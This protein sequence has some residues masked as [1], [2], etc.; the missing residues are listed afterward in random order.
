MAAAVPAVLGHAR[1]GR[2]QQGAQGRHRQAYIL[3]Y[4]LIHD[5][6]PSL[7]CSFRTGSKRAPG[8][9]SIHCTLFAI[10]SAELAP[11]A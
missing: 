5:E 6:S 11:N 4:T 3:T 1:T 2:P 8:R 10:L 7:V 9:A